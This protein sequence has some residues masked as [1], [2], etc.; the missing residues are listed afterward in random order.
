MSEKHFSAVCI[1]CAHT[2]KPLDAHSPCGL[3][4]EKGKQPTHRAH[5][6][7]H[8]HKHKSQTSASA[9]ACADI[10]TNTGNSWIQKS[11]HHCL[12]NQQPTAANTF[13]LSL[14]NTNGQHRTNDALWTDN[15]TKRDGKLF[16]LSPCCSEASSWYL[17]HNYF[18]RRAW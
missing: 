11:M 17:L 18:E 12:I 5:A 9:N 16:W 13:R 10:E 4:R 6:H 1:H 8:T 2:K 7:K 15:M 14:K 3:T